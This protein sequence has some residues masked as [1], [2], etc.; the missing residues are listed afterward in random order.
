MKVL[1]N[2]MLLTELVTCY[3]S[4]VA[5]VFGSKANLLDPCGQT[6]RSRGQAFV[7]VDIVNQAVE[8]KSDMTGRA[9]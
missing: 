3:A 5:P 1:K 7:G 9:Q 6:V 4:T 8:S 2:G